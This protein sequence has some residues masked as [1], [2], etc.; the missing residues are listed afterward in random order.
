MTTI[1]IVAVPLTVSL[2]FVTAAQLK[3]SRQRRRRHPLSGGRSSTVAASK[4]GNTLGR[5]NLSLTTE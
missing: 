2:L 5:A 3:T 1:R 4:A